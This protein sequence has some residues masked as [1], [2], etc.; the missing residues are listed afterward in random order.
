MDNRHKSSSAFATKKMKPIN[1][2]FLIVHGR[3]TWQNRKNGIWAGLSRA[4]EEDRFNQE[5]HGENKE[6]H[7]GGHRPKPRSCIMDRAANEFDWSLAANNRDFFI[8]L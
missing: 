6:Q 2:S 3:K 4:G 1:Y 8:I 5:L 7:S